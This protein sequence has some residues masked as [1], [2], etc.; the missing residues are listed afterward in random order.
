MGKF[1]FGIGIGV[2][3]TGCIAKPFSSAPPPYAYKFYEKSGTNEQDVI[4][5]MKRCGFSNVYTSPRNETVN[6]VAKQEQCMFQNGFRY[7]NGS[8]GICGA[9]RRFHVDA[10]EDK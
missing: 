8:A 1:I 4:S 2:L 7:K 6:D 3:L 9:S 5:Q 10:C